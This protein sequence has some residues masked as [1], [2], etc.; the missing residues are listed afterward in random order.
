MTHKLKV[1]GLILVAIF[2]MSAVVAS[3]A[4]AGEFESEIAGTTVTGEQI[5][6][7]VTGQAL[8]S[9]EFKTTAGVVKCTPALFHGELA[10]KLQANLK[11]TAA[12]GDTTKATGCLIGGVPGPVIHMR[13]CFYELTA[14][15]TIGA[16]PNR[17]G[18][19]THIKCTTPG[20]EIEVTAAAN[21][22]ITIPAQSFVESMVTL[23]NA[24]G[25]GTAMDFRAV[26]DIKE[27]AYMI[28]GAACPGGAVTMTGA[29]GTP[30][31]GDGEYKGLATFT[32]EKVPPATGP[33]GITV[34]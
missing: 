7:T 17:I 33:I 31:A 25:A 27:M 10:A 22:K 16:D 19:I 12:Y 9:H 24:G 4:Q 34:K 11:L 8:T 14:G 29:K 5:S 26:I 2:A 1:L 3:A 6:G 20:D 32:G 15:N 18:A 23:E 30:T 13:T 28:D 21:C